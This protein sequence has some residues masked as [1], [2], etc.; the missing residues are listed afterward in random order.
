LNSGPTI[1]DDFKS[2]IFQPFSQADSSDTRAKGGT[3]L[4]LNIARQIVE[5]M[6]GKI[7]FTSKANSPTVFWFTLPLAEV[8]NLVN[9]KY[10]AR[11]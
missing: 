2:R 10:S 4:G 8:G 1:P 5:R 9:P 3:G 7:G 6:D 11:S